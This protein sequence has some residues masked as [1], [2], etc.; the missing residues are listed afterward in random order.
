MDTVMLSSVFLGALVISAGVVLLFA[1]LIDG[2]LER[3]FAGEMSSAWSLFA[4]FAL[5]VGA[6][7]SGLRLADMDL[8]LSAVQARGAQPPLTLGKGMLEVLKTVSGAL[9]G[10]VWMLLL[11]FGAALVFS[12]AQGLY[13]RV[14]S[15]RVPRGEP[16]PGVGVAAGRHARSHEPH[17]SQ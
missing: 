16:E 10:A 5:F 9:N 4:K 1:A 14:R 8:L 13:A 2:V 12:L 7:T 15:E 17:Q 6:L 3:L 11:I